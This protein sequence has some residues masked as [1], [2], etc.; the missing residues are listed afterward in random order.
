MQVRVCFAGLLRRYIGE[1][2]GSLDL[3]EGATVDDLIMEVAV[4]YRDRFPANFLPEG[5]HS[6]TRLIQASRRGG[7]FYKPGEK[8]EEGAEIML[9]S[10]L[11]G[12]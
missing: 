10:R 3:P 5:Q 8:L 7:P 1:K 2:E 12:G 6:F 11:A 9:M 4:V